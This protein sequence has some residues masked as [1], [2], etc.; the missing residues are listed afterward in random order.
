MAS[1]FKELRETNRDLQKRLGDRDG[2]IAQTLVQ[3]EKTFS[4]AGDTAR[5][6]RGIV[7]AGEEGV[8]SLL[9]HLD[10]AARNL[11]A[12]SDDLR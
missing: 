11:N 9:R 5:G 7:R 1:L 10:E 6:G 8:A 3:V 2:R 12:M 4:D